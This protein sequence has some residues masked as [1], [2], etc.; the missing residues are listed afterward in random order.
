MLQCIIRARNDKSE[1]E[2]SFRAREILPKFLRR[3][4]ANAPP[5]LLAP[6]R[7]K[8]TIKAVRRANV[9]RGLEPAGD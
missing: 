6:G 7:W 2:L 5:N 9:A 1:F 3:E 4:E 8:I